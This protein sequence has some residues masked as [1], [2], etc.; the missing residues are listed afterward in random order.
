M[1]GKIEDEYSHEKINNGIRSLPLSGSLIPNSQRTEKSE[2]HKLE[3]VLPISIYF[4]TSKSKGS[5]RET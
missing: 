1:L 2:D 5:R 3:Q 4:L